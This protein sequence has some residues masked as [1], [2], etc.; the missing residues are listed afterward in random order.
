[1]WCV[2]S[3]AHFTQNFLFKGEILK[4]HHIHIDWE[5][6]FS[7]EDLSSLKEDD[8]D[9]GVYQ[10]YG[11]HPLY[12][13]NVLLY[14]GRAVDQTFGK[15]ISQ[16]GWE[17]NRDFENVSIYIGRLSGKETPEGNEWDNEI[18][19]AESLL[20]YSH[21]PAFNAQSIRSVPD[22]RLDNVHV[23]NWVA[24]RDLMSEVSGSRWKPTKELNDYVYYG[25][26]EL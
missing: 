17:E 13:S 8:K 26:H 6:P 14:I 18:I 5:G 23:F 20:I 21:K 1:M 7:I 25:T 4:S 15:R 9:Y 2:R 11:G 10:I 16:E 24:H 12:G 3:R 19:L 22:K